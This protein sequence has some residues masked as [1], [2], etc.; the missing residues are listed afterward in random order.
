MRM[1]D[2]APLTTFEINGTECVVLSRTQFDAIMAALDDRIDAAAA[3]RAI[4]DLEGR[5][6]DNLSV[7]E[8]AEKDKSPLRFWRRRRGLTQADLA[9]RAGLSQAYV[10]EIESGAKDGSPKAMARLA[11]TLDVPLDDL[12]G[13][14]A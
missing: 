2:I 9:G 3:A 8:I 5:E 4:A 1:S 13:P 12:L 11:R 14:D 10:A 7:V 6:S